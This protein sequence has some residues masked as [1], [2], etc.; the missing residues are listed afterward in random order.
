MKRRRIRSK[1]NLLERKSSFNQLKTRKEKINKF[2]DEKTFEE[3]IVF[4]Q[5]RIKKS[6]LEMEED[7]AGLELL[8]KLK[9][10]ANKRIK[11][12]S[13]ENF[14]LREQNFGLKKT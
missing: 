7:K 6:F 4:L 13:K 14:Y 8:N 9:M 11:G 3:S 2:V 5:E 12:L 1:K 10:K